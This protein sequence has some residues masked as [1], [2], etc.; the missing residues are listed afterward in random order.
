MSDVNLFEIAT[1]NKYRFD[2]ARGKM[3]VE[4]LWDLPLYGKVSLDQIEIDLTKTVKENQESFAKKLSRKNTSN[5]YKLDIV[6][7]I[8]EYKIKEKEKK[9]QEMANKVRREKIMQLIEE[10]E[11]EELKNK[12]I[13]ELKKMI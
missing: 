5:D 8:I 7:Y 2:T 10:R 9:E 1:R 3:S 4:D 6:R 11:L 13:D 12:P